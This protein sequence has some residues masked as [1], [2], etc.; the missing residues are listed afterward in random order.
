MVKV[1]KFAKKKKYGG[2]TRRR[3]RR[4][5]RGSYYI[6]KTYMSLS[7]HKYK[8]VVPLSNHTLDTKVTAGCSIS[9]GTDWLRLIC[10]NSIG[11]KY[12]S[13]G[14]TFSLGNMQNNAEFTTLYDAYKLDYIVVKLVPLQANASV[15]STQTTNSSGLICHYISD[16]DDGTSFTASATGVS[17]MCECNGYR[18]YNNPVSLNK[19]KFAIK[20]YV[21]RTVYQSG[22]TAAYG[23]TKS[24][25][26]DMGYPNVPHNAMKWIFVTHNT[27]N[28]ALEW[29][30]RAE[31]TYYFT[32]RDVR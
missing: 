32:C 22:L 28:V 3:P 8:R 7:K 29:Y 2:V 26:L 16:K 4:G 11:T 21:S 14:L 27:S 6:Q 17:D 1:T 24:M 19:L 15:W 20:P 12:F 18:C 31:A 9:N 10:D 23:P 5:T 30:F 25:W 13:I